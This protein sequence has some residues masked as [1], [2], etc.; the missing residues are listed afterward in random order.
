M[1]PCFDLTKNTNGYDKT[2]LKNF[3]NINNFVVTIKLRIE[4]KDDKVESFTVNFNEVQ[5][6]AKDLTKL[7]PYEYPIIILNFNQTYFTTKGIWDQLFK[8]DKLPTSS[9]DPILIKKNNLRYFRLY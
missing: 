1:Y 2:F 9:Y 4:G 7:K 5:F 6:L 3:Q 8:E